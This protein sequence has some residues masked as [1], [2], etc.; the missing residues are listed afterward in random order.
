MRIGIS[1]LNMEPFYG[2]SFSLTCPV[3]NC[4]TFTSYCFSLACK[5]KKTTQ[6]LLTDPPVEI[7]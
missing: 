3:V 1:T 5:G 2:V 4:L 6:V 7:V